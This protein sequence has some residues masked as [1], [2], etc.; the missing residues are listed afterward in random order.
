MHTHTVGPGA[1][2]G[3]LEALTKFWLVIMMLFL[4]PLLGVPC[5]PYN[6]ISRHTRMMK[7]GGTNL[8]VD[9]HDKRSSGSWRSGSDVLLVPARYHL[10][11]LKSRILAPSAPQRRCEQGRLITATIRDRPGRGRDAPSSST[12]KPTYVRRYARIPYA[13]TLQWIVAVCLS[14][15]VEIQTMRMFINMCYINICV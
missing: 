4:E 3:R 6:S 11:Q 7:S 5:V 1:Q 14:C 10:R 2:G 9:R 13:L 12:T 15:A 8:R